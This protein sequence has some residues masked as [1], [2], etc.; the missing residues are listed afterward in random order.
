MVPDTSWENPAAPPRKKGLSLFGKVAIGCG[1]ALLCFLL[2]IGAAV[3]L[4]FSKA[5]QAL[6]KGWAT[7]HTQIHSLRTDEGVRT[8]YRE[9]PGLAQTYATEAEFLK[10]AREWRP[11]LGDIPEQRPD[12]RKLLKE[13]TGAGVVIKSR[14]SSEGKVMVVNITM[15]TGAT[16]VVE[17]RDD[18][19]VDIQV[20]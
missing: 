15:S 2:A 7:V 17:L 14:D 12:L 13:H 8:L 3:W 20:D 16:L 4:V 1:S 19:L 9:N 10:A 11:K 18:K 5:T 6:D